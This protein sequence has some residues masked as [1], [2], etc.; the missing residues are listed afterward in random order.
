MKEEDRLFEKG[1]EGAEELLEFEDIADEELV[2]DTALD[3]EGRAESR[4][5]EEMPASE[6]AAVFQ[7]TEELIGGA[8]EETIEAIITRVVQDVVER[9]TREAMTTVAERVIGEA[10]DALKQSLGSPEG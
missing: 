10:I 1:E 5:L 2:E 3:I 6:K 4:G 8:S 7:L 9:V